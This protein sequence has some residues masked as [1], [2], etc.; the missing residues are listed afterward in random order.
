M[1]EEDLNSNNREDAVKA[2]KELQTATADDY[3]YLYIVN[4]EHSY[5]VKDDLDISVDTQ[6][7]HPHGHGAPVINNMN[8]WTLK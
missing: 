7:P 2:W 5:F 6:I 3:A 8:E 4:I 1:V